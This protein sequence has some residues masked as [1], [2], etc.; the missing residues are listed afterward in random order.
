ML[1][2]HVLS[3]YLVMI[4]S[5]QLY[6]SPCLHQ[7]KG[8]LT[9]GLAQKQGRGLA[10]QSLSSVFICS[11]NACK[12]RALFVPSQWGVLKKAWEFLKRGIGFPRELCF[13]SLVNISRRGQQSA[14]GISRCVY[15]PPEDYLDI[16][17][18]ASAAAGGRIGLPPDPYDPMQTQPQPQGRSGRDSGEEWL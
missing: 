13:S 9:S 16:L 12:Q 10:G 8:A 15:Q 2:L 4:L 3:N 5:P 17:A 6:P 14:L 7:F 18:A 1:E 11:W